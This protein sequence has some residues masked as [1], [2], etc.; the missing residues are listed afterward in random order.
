MSWSDETEV[1]TTR[2]RSEV[3][4]EVALIAHV[5]GTNKSKVI[6]EAISALVAARRAD[7]EFKARARSKMRED[8]ETFKR[9]A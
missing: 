1:L 2:V 4:A 6:S 9:F 5:D 7:S 8:I 3:A